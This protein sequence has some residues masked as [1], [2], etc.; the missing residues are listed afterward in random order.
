MAST[1][2]PDLGLRKPALFQYLGYTPHAA[3]L[4]VHRSTAKR[5]VVACGVRWG[6]STV[7]VHEAIVELL[8]PRDRGLAW[9]VAPTYETTKRI[10]ERV[11]IALQTHFPHRI[12]AIDARDRSI[13]V[14]NLGG[15]ESTLRARSADRPVGLLGESLTSLILDEAA[16]ID[17]RVWTEHLAPRLLDRNGSAL[18]L[19]TPNGP[20][21]FYDEFRRAKKDAAYA[22]WT[23]ATSSNPTID[24]ALIEAEGRRLPEEVFA[25]QYLGQFVGVEAEVCEHCQGPTPHARVVI[26]F[27]DE[28]PSYCPECKGLVGDDGVSAVP[29]V[30]GKVGEA[31]I[32]RLHPGPTEPPEMPA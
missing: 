16:H 31:R 21:W 18:L 8:W 24:A 9:L 30:N 19:S 22:A 20:G 26:L 5:R 14:A 7:G 13:T 1:T 23:F 28:Q 27:E 4:L 29:L 25:A 6:K 17:E 12:L 3:Q 32:I 15:G 11:V 10:G 2:T